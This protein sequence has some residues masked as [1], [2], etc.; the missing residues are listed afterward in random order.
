[1]N[2]IS[3]FCLVGYTAKVLQHKFIFISSFK[4]SCLSKLE[5]SSE[6]SADDGFISITEVHYF[7]FYLS[8]A[9]F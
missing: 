4:K 3:H 2:Q 6:S 9:N 8:G 7:N 1:M 5:R